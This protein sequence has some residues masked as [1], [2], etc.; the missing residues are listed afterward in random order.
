M[1]LSIRTTV[2]SFAL[3]A[4]NAFAHD[5][6][7]PP[8]PDPHDATTN[9]TPSSP[10]Y[11]DEIAIPIPQEFRPWLLHW[12][13]SNGFAGSFAFGDI[14]GKD[15]GDLDVVLYLTNE[16]LLAMRVDIDWS[17]KTA[18]TTPLW[19]WLA[20]YAQAP[21]PGG[22][23]GVAPGT[24]GGAEQRN[25]V[26]WDLNGDGTNEVAVIAT[27]FGTNPPWDPPKWHP[28]IFVLRT[29]P[30][31]SGPSPYASVP[32]PLVVDSTGYAADPFSVARRLGICRV[33]DTAFPRDLCTHEHNGNKLGIW[34]L[35]DT[36]Q[37]VLRHQ[38]DLF[39]GKTPGATG[40]THESNY[41]DVDNDGYHEFLFDGL[42][43][44]VDAS[45]PTNPVNPLYGVQLWSTGIAQNDI[46]N[47][48]AWDWDPNR[49]GLEVLAV[50]EVTK[51]TFYDALTG[52]LISVN[53]DG[54]SLHGQVIYP[55]NWT[56][57]R[58]GFEAIIT[59]KDYSG[60]VKPPGEVNGS[61][62]YAI[63][64][65]QE[66]LAVDGVLFGIQDG[67]KP[68]RTSCGP[69]WDVW[70]IDW[71][72]DRTQDEILSVPWNT[73]IV[74]RMG[75]KGDWLP[76]P[77][78]LGMP[79][80]AEVTAGPPAPPPIQG[81]WWVFYYQGQDGSKA[82]Q[83]GWN[84]G[85]VGRYTHYYEKLGEVWPHS[86]VPNGKAWDIAGDH[87]EEVIGYS[88][89]GLYAYANPD[90]LA[91][92]VRP[93]PR[94]SRAYLAVKMD[95]LPQPLDYQALPDLE[96]ISIEPRV[97]GMPTGASTQ[98]S[99]IAHF[100]DGTTADVTKLAAWSDDGLGI[101]D[102]QPDGRIDSTAGVAGSARVVAAFDVGGTSYT[103][104][105]AWVLATDSEKSVVLLAGYEETHL[106]AG[107][108]TRPLHCEAVVAQ[109]DNLPSLVALTNADGTFWTPN[110]SVILMRDNG[111]PAIGDE[112]AGDGIYSALLS[113]PPQPG[114][115]VSAGDNLKGILAV[116]NEVP[117]DLAKLSDPWPYFSV[118]GP[119]AFID[120][121]SQYDTDAQLEDYMPKVRRCGFRGV[122]LGDQHVFLEAEV[123]PPT[124]DLGFAIGVA[125]W[126]PWDPG[127]PYLFTN[128]GDGIHVLNHTIGAPPAPTGT[129]VVDVQAF[130]IYPGG[131]VYVSDAWPRIRI[132]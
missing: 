74:W 33:R 61:G 10:L 82:T 25:V 65:T 6:E 98:L 37:L 59:P 47:M 54:P 109:R 85:G 97:S 52:A 129:H 3:L 27:E 120:I 95:M 16:A 117:L 72:G 14:E 7:W 128:Q 31:A 75:E 57:T 26:I 115:G 56:S 67:T 28:S 105:P 9:P 70:Q 99:A 130:I 89:A 127:V 11:M 8:A 55:G 86:N 132:H 113:P 131:L 43:D 63:S 73:M 91:G 100:G 20:P 124:I 80:M 90:P 1:L 104:E 51:D 81:T 119:P 30:N 96:R 102:L 111:S 64:S 36:D 2:L 93:S 24:H 49:P 39:N 87:R 15:D 66:E 110:G 71:D 4:A 5:S 53:A 123:I 60:T 107:D 112:E 77:P 116:P 23:G 18:T 79:A 84:N 103:S 17:T 21:A 40:S 106:V 62:G 94:L 42:V 101:L 68:P 22:L 45:G 125:A 41:F 88:T 48:Q 121:T 35:D 19:F 58:D 118:G 78:P 122:D 44:F 13:N 92:P 76:G 69:A 32:E 83:W 126:F 114:Q 34:M 29:D 38:F 12:H 50:P 46:D 108:A